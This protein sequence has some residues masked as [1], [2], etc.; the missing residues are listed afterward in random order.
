[1]LVWF[2]SYPIFRSTWLLHL[3]CDCV[4]M[5][6]DTFYLITPFLCDW[7]R[8]TTT[9]SCLDKQNVENADTEKSAAADRLLIVIPFKLTPWQSCIC[10]CIGRLLNG[11]TIGHKKNTVEFNQHLF[12]PQPN[13]SR[14]HTSAMF[15]QS[16]F[17]LSRKDQQPKYT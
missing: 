3:T 13:P 17:I 11:T 1:M 16:P 14:A 5:T 15:Q 8:W 6:F 2:S 10:N 12:H 4:N 7:H 9:K